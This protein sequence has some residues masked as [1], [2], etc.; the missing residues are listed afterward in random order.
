[1]RRSWHAAL[2]IAAA[3]VS[4]G[5]A[6]V[7][8]GPAQAAR[9]A[10][11][12]AAATALG[13]TRD[14]AAPDAAYYTTAGALNGVA[15][16]SASSAWAVGYTGAKSSGK[17]L[18][19]H[20]NGKAWSRVTSPAVLN[21]TTGELT[22]IT[23]VSATNAWAVGY[24]GAF[25]SGQE[26]SLILHW[27]GSA[28]SEVT[29]PA[30]IA[31]GELLGVTATATS[32]W[33]VGYLDINRSAP[34]CCEG[35]PLVLRLSGT[36]WSR[37]TQNFGSGAGF[38][39]VA[40]TGPG[41][42]WAI[43]EPTAMIT[44][45]V[46]RW[47]GSTW[48]L[49]A[50]PVAGSHHPLYGIAAGPG[51]TAFTV[52]DNLDMPGPPV[53][54]RLTGTAWKAVTVS[55]PNG[56]SLNAVAF[57]PGGTAWAAGS[58]GLTTGRTMIMRWN[59]SAWTRMASP[60]PSASDVLNGIGFSA[61][62]DGWAVGATAGKTLILHWNGTAWGVPPTPPPPATGYRT[63]GGLTGVATASNSSAWAVG[64]AGTAA[65][66]MVLM[67][68][69]NGA[70]WA[71]VTSPAVLTGAG[72]LNAITVVS[73]TDAWAVGY[74][75]TS[76][77]VTQKTLI[78]HWNGSAWGQVTSP[79]PIAGALDAVTATATSGWAVG[80]IPNGHN[81]PK[82][83]A[84]RL[85]G[86]TWSRANAGSYGIEMLGVA[87]AGSTSWAI[88]DTEQQS[89]V[90][91]WTGSTWT[92]QFPVS[93]QA[94]Y[95][96]GG[97]AAGPGGTA[98]AVG[99]ADQPSEVPASLKLTGTTWKPVPVSAPA[100][101]NLDA[102]TYAPGGTA[103]AAGQTSVFT[104]R[105]VVMR[106][107]GS[108]WTRVASASPTSSDALAGLGFSAASYGWAVGASGSSTLVLHWNGS[109]WG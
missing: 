101:A 91:H 42:S 45:F 67:V 109:T 56:S 77:N 48:A 85:S 71:R 86:T 79:A 90:G 13:S 107:N 44:G 25:A 30:P 47:N 49:G 102:V 31:A 35:A 15:A 69:W 52:G 87:T 41:T 72:R 98:F 38:P 104:G 50:N 11:A 63:A 55:A 14:A 83:L 57:A 43:G 66:P 100:G 12:T 26:H 68:H 27:N 75:G 92:W 3:C 65:S 108:A 40:T 60:S 4:V 58:T 88:G 34:A 46:E 24:T 21:G 103:W 28:W 105:T 76:T 89:E 78:L 106:W 82:S 64:Y 29:S 73:A 17:V 80:Y 70:K 53:S 61:A 5:L 36:T 7:L 51:G 1:M 81:F 16:A 99:L 74:T 95:V 33:A 39:G 93:A 37:S 9:T 18:M 96:L 2:A 54:A 59:G 20:W 8:A 94:F 23:V 62:K 22:A 10:A 32:G 97:I 84:V 6:S 19:L